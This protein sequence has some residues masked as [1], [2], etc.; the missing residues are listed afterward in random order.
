LGKKVERGKGMLIEEKFTVK[1]PREKVWAFLMDP[2]SLA[3]CVPGCE[4]VK[5]VDDKNFLVTVKVKIAF[6][7]LAFDMKVEITEMSPPAHLETSAAGE[8]TSMTSNIK[9]KNVIDLTSLSDRET[10]VSYRSDVSLFGKL[11][12]MGQS[13]VKGKAKQVG[14]E[15]AAAVKKRLESK[16]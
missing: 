13:V 2:K 15:F 16:A 7:S 1:A 10:E 8:E 5:A 14:K 9:A 4:K 3:P 6:V 12:T 11:G